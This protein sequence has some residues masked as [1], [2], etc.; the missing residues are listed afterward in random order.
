M[1]TVMD[2]KRL[3][4]LEAQL[5]EQAEATQATN[6][7]IM[8]LFSMM[9]MQKVDGN[10]A[11]PPSPLVSLPSLAPLEGVFYI[12]LSRGVCCTPRG[13]SQRAQ[14]T[15]MVTDQRD[16]PSSPPASF[17]CRSQDQTTQTNNRASTRHSRFS[18]PDVRRHL[19]NE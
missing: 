4:N 7:L 12:P 1:S 9:R 11:T 16:M 5:R 13:L 15:L 17:T 8:Q 18:S 3:Q 2:T 10:V 14:T 19:L 6:G